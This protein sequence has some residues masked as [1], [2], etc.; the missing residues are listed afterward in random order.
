MKK[1]ISKLR[2]VLAMFVM[3]G[4]FGMSNAVYAT[5]PTPQQPTSGAV[6]GG[7]ARQFVEQSSG[8]YAA[9]AARVLSVL[10][11]FCSAGAII[12]QIV[13]INRSKKTYME[14][15]GVITF[16]LGIVGV[17]IYVLSLIA[18]IFTGNTY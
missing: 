5:L 6:T 9:T 7:N 13:E 17:S 18:P 3:L 12:Y 2:V 15:G 16:A 11:I 14:A 10:A 8:D 1:M 4:S